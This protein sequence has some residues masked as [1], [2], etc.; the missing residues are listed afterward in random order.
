[1]NINRRDFV[2]VGTSALLGTQV[3]TAR[4]NQAPP[5]ARRLHFRLNALSVFVLDRAL[6]VTGI[7]PTANKSTVLF[8]DHP[9]HHLP[10]VYVAGA[11]KALVLDKADLRIKVGGVE[12]PAALPIT[13]V[14]K[15]VVACPTYAEWESL[16]CAPVIEQV[17]GKSVHVKS[18]C[19]DKNNP[20]H[21]NG[22]LLLAGGTLQG[23]PPE[24]P[25]AGERWS[26]PGGV[27]GYTRSLT[28]VLE[29]VVD[30]AA[31][32]VTLE[33]VPF[34]SAVATDSVTVNPAGSLAV[35][36][37]SPR[38]AGLA[39]LPTGYMPHFAHYYDLLDYNAA[40]KPIP[41]RANVGCIKTTLDLT[42][43]QRLQLQ[44][45]R[46]LRQ[47]FKVPLAEQDDLQFEPA[48]SLGG[49]SIG[50]PAEHLAE[51]ARS[52]SIF[53]VPIITLQPL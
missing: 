40:A 18:S 20:T 45:F 41:T 37:S 29:W 39:S 28:D 38:R 27:P 30:I 19:L 42:Q 33:A 5:A 14:N 53:C 17:L 10:H 34:G 24:S 26:F 11:T 50:E 1:M 9:E 35:Y 12:L 22:R 48:A 2:R 4:A 47:Q 15:P 44:Q 21:I 23:A 31:G 3:M 51:V 7:P 43:Q 49:P 32:S 16:S 13:L 25:Y 36:I 6:N 8:A 52:E 46:N